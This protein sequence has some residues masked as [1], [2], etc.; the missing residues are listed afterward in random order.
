[1]TAA[2][3]RIN[4]IICGTQCT[5]KMWPFG[6][7]LLKEFQ[8]ADSKASDNLRNPPGSHMSLTH[9]VGDL[10]SPDIAAVRLTWDFSIPSKC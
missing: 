10:L 9:E 5:V 7:K 8:E 2:S 3:A 1:M 4:Y 6:S